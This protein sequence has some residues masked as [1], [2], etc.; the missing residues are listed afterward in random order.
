MSIK[1]NILGLIIFLV[2]VSTSMAD[3]IIDNVK[4]FPDRATVT[5][6]IDRSVTEGE[7]ELAYTDLPVG[8]MRDSVRITAQGPDGFR[9]GGY[10]LATRRGSE[11]VD[12]RARQLSERIESLQ[13]Q[14]RL[15]DASVQS[16]DLQLALLR[17]FTS[18]ESG[19][20]GPDPQALRE[21]LQLVGEGSTEVLEQKHALGLEQRRLDREIER[22]K[23]EL[24]D[25]GQQQSDTTELR[26]RYTSPQ[27]G[28]VRL[29]IEYTVAAA[30]WRPVYEW[31]LD[32]QN[33]R[34]EIVQFAE[35][36]QNTGEDWTQTELILSLAQPATGG[37]LPELQPWWVN[38]APPRPPA[39]QLRSDTAAAPMMAETEAFMDASVGAAPGWDAAELAGTPYTQQYHVA[40]RQSIASDNQPRRFHLADYAL[41]AELSARTVPRRQA[42]AWLYAQAEFDGAAPLPP[43][44]VTLYQDRTLI[45]QIAFGGAVSGATL[46]SS[47]GT[48]ERIEIDYQLTA[49]ERVSEGMIRR[50]IRLTR[51]FKISVVNRHERPMA[52]MVLDQMP[53]SR[54]E[55]LQVE[56]TQATT[57]PDQR[58]VDD[59]PGIL[60]WEREL[61]PG[62]ETNL[63][64][65]YQLVFPDDLSI[66][67]W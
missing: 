50:S 42:T 46:A 62:E 31:W 47:F 15:I 38:I 61:V 67:G 64:I 25:L 18:I 48:D 27:A 30:L 3:E 22:L 7:G 24:A 53:V 12:P 16:R 51:E 65:G 52:L 6:Q 37:R 41:D 35:V 1:R 58:D 8:L 11:Q 13:D 26:V 45:G 32:T 60:A 5:R 39:R 66:T 29:A 9:L 56:F 20:A 34:L 19:E 2:L 49:D 28:D 63:I 21:T 54:D 17:S 40:G 59:K 43:G 33:G 10:A 4:I 14:R 36:R 57:T 44:S 23:R 55:R